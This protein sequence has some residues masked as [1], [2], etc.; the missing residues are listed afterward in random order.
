[1]PELR[2]DPI[3]RR[4]TIIATERAWRPRDFV[5]DPRGTAE[6]D[7]RRPSPFAPG[8]EHLT[9]EE[10]YALRPDG[11]APNTP[12]WQVRVIPN[13]YPVL[14]VEGGLDPQPEG[15]YDRMN[16]LGAH[17]VIIESPDPAFK[18]HR[19]P[20]EHLVSALRVY[21]DRMADL[22]GDF[23]LK[24][25]CLFRNQ[26]A[27]AGA[28]VAHGHAQLVALP[29]VPPEVQLRLDGSKSWFEVRG[30]NVFD[31]LIRQEVS[32][33][34]RLVYDNGTFVVV[35]PYASMHP[36]DMWVIPRAPQSHFDCTDEGHLS[37]LADALQQALGRLEVGLGDPAWNLMLHT[38]PYALR[39]PGDQALPWYRWHVVIQ[40]KLTQVA[41]FERGTGTYINPVAPESAAQFLRGVSP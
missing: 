17:E 26:G 37:G 40:P 19:L 38:T 33:G 41:G 24:Y 7:T 13:K 9:P 4:W 5:H 14:A 22:R 29:V 31:D 30:R 23:R 12:G 16:G 8:N 36:F 10:I 32:Q 21:R 15:L 18:L 28:S 6:V 27:A 35:T 11:S 1:M 34:D 39:G 20:S 3:T 2:R 25:S